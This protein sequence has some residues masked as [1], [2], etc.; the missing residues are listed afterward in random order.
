[1]E[2]YA[3]P[4]EGLFSVRM[5]AGTGEK[6]LCGAERIVSEGRISETAG[7]MVER[8]MG[9]RQEGMTAFTIQVDLV[10]PD[11]IRKISLLPIR[12]V[13]TE[14]WL[15]AEQ[16]A[17]SLLVSAGVARQV[18]REALQAVGKG[19]SPSGGNMRGGMV[20][21]AGTGKRL[22]PDRERGVRVTRMDLAEEIR[23]T[24]LEGLKRRG[25]FHPRV[26]EAVIL[27]S[28]VASV[29]GIVA[30]FCRSDDP[31]YTTGY[32]ASRELGYVR[33]PHIKE[34]GDH[35]GGRV[36]FLKPGVPPNP[37]I[38]DLERL[39]CL[40]SEAEVGD[41]DDGFRFPIE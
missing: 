35:F 24:I 8:A 36:F 1:M 28:K 34:R 33:L 11:Q 17:L 9:H 27:A 32:V 23:E 39:P 18:A 25:I 5:H 13:K 19:A 30:E 12:T 7:R 10:D 37:V 38:R 41:A 20:V 40:V 15:Q 26:L 21:D 2:V 6:H 22:E 3:R 31:A 4:R 16:E 29:P 14:G